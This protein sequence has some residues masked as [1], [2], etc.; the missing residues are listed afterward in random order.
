[1]CRVFNKSGFLIFLDYGYAR[2]LNF[3]GYTGFTYFRKYDSILS[4]FGDATME[5][6]W[7]FQDSE[8]ARLLH[9]QALHK[10]RNMPEYGRTV[11]TMAVFRTCMVKISQGF[12]YVY[13]S[14]CQGLKY[15]KVLSIWRLHRV[16]SIPE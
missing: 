5:G 10:I 8:Y 12:E 2:V 15:G 9:M 6:F 4:M 14:N 7:T 3:Q 11:L 13:G 1:M 16:L